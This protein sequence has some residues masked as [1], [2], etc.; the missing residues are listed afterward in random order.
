MAYQNQQFQQQSQ[1]LHDLLNLEKL[2]V[3]DFGAV[4]NSERMAV[5]AA[6]EWGLI[7][8]EVHCPI[9]TCQRIMHRHGHQT[10]KLRFKWRCKGTRRNP[11][12]AVFVNP[13]KN[14]FFANSHF[15]Q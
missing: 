9:S 12:G 7:P 4:I 6:V 14:T 2:S 1:K 13:L 8:K 11:H 3:W 10:H 5:T 15:W